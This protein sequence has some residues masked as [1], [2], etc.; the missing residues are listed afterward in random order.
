MEPILLNLKEA[1][2]IA[3]VSYNVMR[4]LVSKK[5]IEAKKVGRRYMF[6]RAEFAD[7][8]KDMLLK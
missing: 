7:L 8:I 5:R 6:V 2:K 3:G 4:S 1:A